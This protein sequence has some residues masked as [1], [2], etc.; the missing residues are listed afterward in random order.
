MCYN[1]PHMN[2]F[3]FIQSQPASHEVVVD[4]VAWREARDFQEA[5]QKAAKFLL[6]EYGYVTEPTTPYQR[7][8]AHRQYQECGLVL[9]QSTELNYG[10]QP[11]F[12][13]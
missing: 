12:G 5:Q 7:F 8:M 4:M 9:V 11:T 13:S 3:E 10:Q 6:E 2:S 1:T